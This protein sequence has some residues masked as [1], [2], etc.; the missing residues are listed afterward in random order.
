MFS[1]FPQDG[2]MNYFNQQT[3][4]QGTELHDYPSGSEVNPFN[5]CRLQVDGELIECV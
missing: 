2:K 4:E 3:A 1:L 5:Q